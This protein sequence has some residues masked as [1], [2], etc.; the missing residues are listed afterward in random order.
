MFMGVEAQEPSVTPGVLALSKFLA[1]PQVT[2]L[3]DPL[4]QITTL[5]MP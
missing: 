5:H 4:S 1:V 2:Q 3:V